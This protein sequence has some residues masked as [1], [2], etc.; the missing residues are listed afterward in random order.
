MLALV[1]KTYQKLSIRGHWTVWS[2]VFNCS[3]IEGHDLGVGHGKTNTKLF[4][5]EIKEQ[6]KINSC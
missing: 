2:H 5:Y 6:K 4:K 1:I 3:S